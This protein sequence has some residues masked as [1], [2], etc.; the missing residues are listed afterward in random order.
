MKRIHL[1]AAFALLISAGLTSCKKDNPEPNDNSSANQTGTARLNL[2]H[3]WGTGNTGFTLNSQLIHPMNGDTLTFTTLKYYISNIRFRKNDGSWY[4]QPD[5]YYLVDLSDESSAQIS[6]SGIPTGT[7]TEMQYTLGVDS[8]RN[9]SGA[10]SGAL[11]VSNDMF[12][13]W[14]SGYIMIKA[15]GTS[16]NSSSGSFAYHLGGFSG[17]NSA[18]ATMSADLSATNLIVSAGHTSEVH[19]LVNTARLMHTTSVETL[20]A[21]HMPGADAK[22]MADDF[23]SGFA[24]DHIHN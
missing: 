14:N 10:Q 13:S 23:H 6:V 12:W 24:F 2:E 20:N 7:Y 3:M 18:V 21:I 9:V 15:E 1:L 5:S 8:A 11:S 17:T 4:E 22:V 16:P 19:M